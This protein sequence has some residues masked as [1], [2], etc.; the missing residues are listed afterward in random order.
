MFSII[1]SRS[2]GWKPGDQAWAV[3]LNNDGKTV[4]GVQLNRA[5]HPTFTSI[6]GVV[7]SVVPCKSQVP[8]DHPC[9]SV[10]VDLDEAGVRNLPRKE[11]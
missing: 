6:P 4:T 10:T 2:H 9:D 1:V 11:G 7:K 3:L 8:L 5:C